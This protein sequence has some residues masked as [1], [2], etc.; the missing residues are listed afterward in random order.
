M[1]FEF[2]PPNGVRE[3]V[4]S[5]NLNLIIEPGRSLIANTCCL[6]NRVIGVKTNGTKNFIVIDGSMSELIRPS[7]YGAYQHI[8]LVSPLQPDA[9][10][11][12]FDVVGPVCESADFLGKD[13]E[14]PTPPREA[15][16][17]G[18]RLGGSRC[19]RLL[20][21]YGINLQSQDAST[22]VLGV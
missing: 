13:R 9:E 7:L 19:W 17:S 8:E 15:Y 3:L 6:V 5:R 2:L 4:L 12:N 10:I 11:S 14:L 18:Y 20:H 16:F 21:E 1:A 22:R